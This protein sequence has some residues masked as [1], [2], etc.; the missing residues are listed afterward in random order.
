M[1]WMKRALC[2]IRRKRIKTFLLFLI[3]FVSVFAILGAWSVLYASDQVGRRIKENS[4]SKVTMESM[5]QEQ[6]LDAVDVDAK[7]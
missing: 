5:D 1:T 4:N 6:M 7:P 3:F 2:Y